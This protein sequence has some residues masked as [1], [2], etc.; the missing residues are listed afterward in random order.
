VTGFGPNWLV[1]LLALA[2]DLGAV[3]QAAHAV[4]AGEQHL[5]VVG[6]PG[7]SRGGWRSPGR[8][9]RC[10]LVRQLTP[11][12]VRSYQSTTSAGRPPISR[13]GRSW[14][15]VPAY[16]LGSRISNPLR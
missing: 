3:D 8:A 15:V 7:P 5:V 2:D 13:V 10:D 4:D 9:G 6:Q 11:P 1:G 14:T 16:G 12:E